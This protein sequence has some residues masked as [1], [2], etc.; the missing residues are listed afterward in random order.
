MI[1]FSAWA[2]PLFW[3][4]VIWHLGS[5]GFSESDTRGLFDSLFS[6]LLPWLSA[7]DLTRTAW[8]LRKLAHPTVYGLLALLCWRAASLTLD[9]HRMS[10]PLWA[11]LPV[12]LLAVADESTQAFSQSRSGALGDVLLDVAG[13]LAVVVAIGRLEVLRDAPLFGARRSA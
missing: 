1:W 8:L 2:P 12:G 13:G 4:A 3:G 5:D 7:E 10:R 6:R 11:L 9:G